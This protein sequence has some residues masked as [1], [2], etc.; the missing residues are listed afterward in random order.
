[1]DGWESA[2]CVHG[3]MDTSSSDSE[4]DWDIP[5]DY[6][7]DPDDFDPEEYKRAKAAAAALAPQTDTGPEQLQQ[8][9]LTTTTTAVAAAYC[10]PVA[11][12]SLVFGCATV[13]VHVLHGVLGFLDIKD[14]I[15]MQRVCRGFR[16]ELDTDAF[17]GNRM[18]QD[19]SLHCVPA[20]QASG[21]SPKHYLCWTL[22]GMVSRN[23]SSAYNRYELVKRLY[24]C[25]TLEQRR[26][27]QQAECTRFML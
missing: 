17:W 21:W 10:W 26:H 4:D 24:E 14:V 27:A 11:E 9:S 3:R 15:V 6:D 7:G 1:M 25:V 13:P 8:Q 16:A 18:V 23:V 20:F 22:V 2:H 12:G 19:L 5:E